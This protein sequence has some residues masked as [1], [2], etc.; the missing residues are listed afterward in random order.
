MYASVGKNIAE[1]AGYV[2]NGRPADIPPVFPFL[3]APLTR[4]MN[5]EAVKIVPPIFSILNM[6]LFFEICRAETSENLALIASA[7]LFLNP[8]TI[9]TATRLTPDQCLIFF[10]LLSYYLDMIATPSWYKNLS[11]SLLITLG[12]LVKYSIILY[13][14]PLLLKTFKNSRKKMKVLMLGVIALTLMPWMKWSYENHGTP[15]VSHSWYLIH[16][17]GGNLEYSIKVVQKRFIWYSPLPLFIM[18]LFKWL[19]SYLHWRRIDWEF[20]LFI[21]PF[22]SNLIWYHP[23]LRYLIAA[24]SAVIIASIKLIDA[25]GG[26]NRLIL[27]LI[28]IPFI[29]SSTIEGILM[30]YNYSYTFTLLRDAGNWLKYHTNGSI[31][32]LTQSFRQI[33]Y[34]SGGTTYY[35]PKKEKLWRYIDEMNIEYV[36]LDNYEKT[37]PRYAYNAFPNK[38]LIANFRGLFDYVRIYRVKGG[39]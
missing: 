9:E 11:I 30:T 7:A 37:T 12:F 2:F 24:Q 20:W 6:I 34:Y 31:R 5:G 19:Y 35:F 39:S 15:L 23:T 38:P 18:A 36:S 4:L 25:L 33:S 32:I 22:L 3:L 21:I 26:K 8:I 10:M 28:C 29:A 13:T 1:K 17:I 14:A 16:Y 27:T